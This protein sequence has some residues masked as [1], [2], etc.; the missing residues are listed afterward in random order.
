MD[1]RDINSKK[2]QTDPA[3]VG[4]LIIAAFGLIMMIYYIS[5]AAEETR[6][7]RV[8]WE[9]RRYENIQKGADEYNRNNKSRTNTYYNSN[10]NSTS[11]SG[12]AYNSTS[13]YSNTTNR[14]TVDPSD[15]EIDAYYE[16]YSDEFEDEDDAWDDFEDNDEYWDDY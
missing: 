11:P 8:K 9:T 3:V 2:Q 10:N 15:H 5:T 14:K 6:N 16:D 7:E 13:S 4:I 1:N 12:N